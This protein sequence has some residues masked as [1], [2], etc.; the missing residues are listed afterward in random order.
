MVDRALSLTR[1]ADVLLFTGYDA[2]CA[3]YLAAAQHAAGLLKA[4]YSGPGGCH[5]LA[6]QSRFDSIRQSPSTSTS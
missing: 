4:T 6:V 5:S 3:S 1:L 2:A